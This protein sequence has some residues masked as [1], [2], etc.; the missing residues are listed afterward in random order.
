MMGS[1]IHLHM[2]ANGKDVIAIVS[3]ESLGDVVP[4]AH[5]E[6]GFNFR[7]KNMH[8]FDKKTGMNMVSV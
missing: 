2:N 6:I 8:L 3:T 5:T 1:E 4:E 7:S